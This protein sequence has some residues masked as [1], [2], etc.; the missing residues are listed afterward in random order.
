MLATELQCVLSKFVLC[1]LGD[2]T[3]TRGLHTTCDHHDGAVA[4]CDCTDRG[5]DDD[6]RCG[7]DDDGR[8]SDHDG[9]CGDNR[10][11][12]HKDSEDVSDDHDD[13]DINVHY[14]YVDSKYDD[15]SDDCNDDDGNV[16]DNDYVMAMKM[17]FI[18]DNTI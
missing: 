7:D 3:G 17:I 5:G 16:D 15:S 2:C 11:Y 13:S 18:T 12:I 6:G 14:S 4:S 8:C 1:S 10:G 9:R